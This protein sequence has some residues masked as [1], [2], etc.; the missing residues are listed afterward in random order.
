M[1]RVLNNVAN[2][3]DGKLPAINRWQSAALLQ[4]PPWPDRFR[5]AE[6]PG[7]QTTQDSEGNLRDSFLGLPWQQSYRIARF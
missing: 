3:D 2:I 5:D 6:C 4:H 7:L 1:N